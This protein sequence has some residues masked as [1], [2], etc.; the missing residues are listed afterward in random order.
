MWG[1]DALYVRKATG[2]G[3]VV[4]AVASGGGPEDEQRRHPRGAPGGAGQR[5]GRWGRG[6]ARG[7]SGGACK[8]PSKRL[9]SGC[10]CGAAQQ[11]EG[12]PAALWRRSTN[13]P[14]A[15]R[16]ALGRR[17]QVQRRAACL[18]CCARCA[19]LLR[20]G[21]FV[22]QFNWVPGQVEVHLSSLHQ[23]RWRRGGHVC[24]PGMWLAKCV[25]QQGEGVGGR[26]GRKSR[27]TSSECGVSVSDGSSSSSGRRPA[28]A[29]AA[30]AGWQHHKPLR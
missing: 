5:W 29:A 4:E 18:A 16:G 30:T 27:Q 17:C 10:T 21:W 15:N 2:D 25:A 19:L 14:P 12:G 26:G 11:W 24:V 3:A 8:T 20:H 7:V 13:R 23:R 1:A 22:D 28:A 9:P 6:G